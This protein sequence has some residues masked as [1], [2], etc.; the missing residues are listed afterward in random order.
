VSDGRGPLGQAMA[1]SL[2][3]AGARTIFVG[4]AEPWK[5]FAGEA[6]LRGV[7]GV[8]LVDLDP[9]NERSVADLAA[10]IG[11]KVEILVNI[12]DHVRPGHIFDGNATLRMAEAMDVAVFGTMRLARAFGPAMMAR[13]ADG[14]HGAAAWVNLLSVY[15]LAGL[16][17]LG[18][19]SV[20]HAACLSLS[21]WLRGEL[22]Q[23]GIRLMNAFSGPLETEWFQ[24]MPPPKVAP[25]T[26]AEAVVDGLRRGLEEI[27]VGDVA[28]DIRARLAANA[29]A[30]ERELS[31]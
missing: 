12:A 26:L 29:K 21:H 5:P 18:S 28:N 19:L 15:A 7:P 23:G 4:I 20:S 31:R 16:P 22:A 10:D 30:V 6:A 17:A 8:E 14:D 25:A 3:R 9:T 24:A 27:Y 2:A 11:G 13:G 1:A